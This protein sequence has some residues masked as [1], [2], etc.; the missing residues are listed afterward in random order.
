MEIFIHSKIQ[1]FIIDETCEE[2]NDLF[3]VS[4]QLDIS[5]LTTWKESSV[6]FISITT[7]KI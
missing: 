2:L 6:K 5:F 7:L 3:G 1:A 4:R